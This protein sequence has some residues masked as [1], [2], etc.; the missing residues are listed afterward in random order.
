MTLSSILYKIKGGG[1]NAVRYAVHLRR[2]CASYSVYSLGRSSVHVWMFECTKTGGALG[3]SKGLIG[4]ARGP[5]WGEGHPRVEGWRF[6][7]LQVR[8][9]VGCALAAFVLKYFEHVWCWGVRAFKVVGV[10]R[11]KIQFVL[12]FRVVGH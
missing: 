10:V 9:R 4:Q 8:G 1:V 6:N 5:C 12:C 2:L 11:D 3:S 7:I